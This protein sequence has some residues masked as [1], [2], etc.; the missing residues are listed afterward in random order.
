MA[1]GAVLGGAPPDIMSKGFPGCCCD[2]AEGVGVAGGV[3]S[4]NAEK[5][6][7]GSGVGSATFGGSATVGV[8]FINGKFTFC[9]GACGASNP[10]F[11]VD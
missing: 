3:I 2:G 5:F 4:S 1:G 7:A 10:Q 9:C 11:E 8:V 6:F